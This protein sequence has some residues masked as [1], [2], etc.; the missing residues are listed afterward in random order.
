MRR[1]IDS[2]ENV[3]KIRSTTSRRMEKLSAHLSDYLP[4]ENKTQEESSTQAEEM[5]KVASASGSK[6]AKLHH[7]L[8]Q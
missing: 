2:S 5:R 1:D 6:A 4:K 8:E 3:T 7:D